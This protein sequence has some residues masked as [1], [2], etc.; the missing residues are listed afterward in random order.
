MS[1]G[2]PEE[3]RHGLLGLM[4][5]VFDRPVIVRVGTT[6]VRVAWVNVQPEHA[7]LELDPADMET[8]VDD[9]VLST[10]TAAKA[11]TIRSATEQTTRT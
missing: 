3:K 9:I 1:P 10:V 7:V 5:D 6:L 2:V 11:R 8:A 4:L